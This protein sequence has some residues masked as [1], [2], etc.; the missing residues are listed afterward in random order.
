MTK[1][2]RIE[3]SF[4]NKFDQDRILSVLRRQYNLHNNRYAA[5]LIYAIEKRGLVPMQVVAS[6]PRTYTNGARAGT[7]D[8]VIVGISLSLPTNTLGEV[9]FPTIPQQGCDNTVR[10]LL[11]TKKAA[12]QALTDD[13]FKQFY[14]TAGLFG[15]GRAQLIRSGLEPVVR[16]IKRLALE[17][18]SDLT[19]I[20]MCRDNLIAGDIYAVDI[21]K[22]VSTGSG[23]LVPKGMGAVEAPSAAQQTTATEAEA[24][25]RIRPVETET[26][27]EAF[28]RRPDGTSIEV[29][30]TRKVTKSLVDGRLSGRHTK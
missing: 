27:A 15:P 13:T 23:L 24:A 2:E 21:D 1:I 29:R 26:T 11:I 14:A 19:G 7:T 6:Y 30:V 9:T 12:L 18:L 5:Q 8:H 28:L 17:E 3:F 22:Y 20:D 4:G 16:P 10:D 25:F